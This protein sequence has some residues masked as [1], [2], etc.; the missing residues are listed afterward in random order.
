MLNVY[1]MSIR[2]PNFRRLEVAER[3]I[4]LMLWHLNSEYFGF[5]IEKTQYF[6]SWQSVLWL[7]HQNFLSSPFLSSISD[8]LILSWFSTFK[9]LRR[10]SLCAWPLAFTDQATEAGT[11]R[12][13]ATDLLSAETKSRFP[14][15]IHAWHVRI[16]WGFPLVSITIAGQGNFNFNRTTRQDRQDYIPHF[17]YGSSALLLLPLL[18]LAVRRRKEEERERQCCVCVFSHAQRYQHPPLPI[19]Q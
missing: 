18:S 14:A 8:I 6:S 16:K 7:L 17:R 10:V 5:R 13:H 19:S 11:E 12:N 9:W 4:S 3:W 2:K 1:V 15:L